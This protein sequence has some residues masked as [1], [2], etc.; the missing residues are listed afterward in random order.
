MPAICSGLPSTSNGDAARTIVAPDALGRGAVDLVHEA[1]VRHAKVLLPGVVPELVPGAMRVAD[2]DVDVGRDEGHVVVP[3]VPQDHVGLLLGGGQDLGVVD[4]GEHEVSLREVRL[5][6][7]ALLNR[8][9]VRIEILVALEP[10]HHLFR[11]VAVR[12]GMAE[13]SDPLSV[14]PEEAGN[15]ACRL[16]LA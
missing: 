2:H 5:V 1:D 12:H 14:L 4:P 8:A 3:A 16:A 13:D 9:V 10:L 11:Q 6:L 15:V 7:L